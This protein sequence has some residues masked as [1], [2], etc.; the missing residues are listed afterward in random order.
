MSYKWYVIKFQLSALLL[1]VTSMNNRQQTSQKYLWEA[2]FSWN[3]ETQTIGIAFNREH[4]QQSEITYSTGLPDSPFLKR[5]S[6]TGGPKFVGLTLC[7]QLATIA[8]SGTLHMWT[9][10]YETDERVCL[11][12]EAATYNRN[13]KVIRLQDH[14]YHDTVLAHWIT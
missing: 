11:D 12:F 3:T 14:V 10:Y 8:T 5:L 13:W 9:N 6:L 1:F 4:I 7:P 2:C